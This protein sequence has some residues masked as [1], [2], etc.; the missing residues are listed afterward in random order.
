MKTQTRELVTIAGILVGIPFAA[1]LLLKGD[2]KL[3][4]EPLAMASLAAGMLFTV[5][6]VLSMFGIPKS[7][8]DTA[9]EDEEDDDDEERPRWKHIRLWQLCAGLG[10]PFLL[11]ADA[12]TGDTGN[13]NRMSNSIAFWPGIAALGYLGA[14]IGWRILVAI[15]GGGV[16]ELQPTTHGSARFATDKE[17]KKAGLLNNAGVYLGQYPNLGDDGLWFDGDGHLITVAASG[18]GKGVCSVIPNLLTW[19]GSVICNDPKGENAAV[20]AKRRREMGQEVHVHEPMGSARRPAMGL[21]LFGVQPA[22]LAGY[23]QRGCRRRCRHDGERPCAARQGHVGC[24][25]AFCR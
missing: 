10:I 3:W 14:R 20:T 5:L 22:R 11:Y 25:G 9:E 19:E 18:A 7:P 21:A 24:R 15:F 23:Q 6:A 8:E 2:H 17:I 4:W 16:E 12:V 13:F 1:L